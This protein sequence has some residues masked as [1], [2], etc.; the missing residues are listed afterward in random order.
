MNIEF[1]EDLRN[2]GGCTVGCAQPPPIATGSARI[3]PGTNDDG[4]TPAVI[5]ADGTAAEVAKPVST[6]PLA[7][8]V[9]CVRE[10]TS[11]AGSAFTEAPSISQMVNLKTR[12]NTINRRHHGDINE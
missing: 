12:Y 7:I 11:M 10:F 5:D 1:T 3:I 8:D 2:V 6:V 4:D 9:R